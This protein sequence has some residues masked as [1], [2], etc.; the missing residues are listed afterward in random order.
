MPE[1]PRLEAGPASE[2]GLGSRWRMRLSQAASLNNDGSHLSTE[3]VNASGGA[4]TVPSFEHVVRMNTWRTVFDLEYLA[5]DD[6]ALRVKMPFELRDRSAS[7]RPIESASAAELADMQRALDLHHSDTVLTGVRDVELTAATWWRGAFLGN[8]RIELAYGV[9]LPFGETES[10]P[11]R[12]DSL[13]NLLPHEHVQFGTGTFDPLVQ[14]TWAAPFA[15]HWATGLY[16]SLRFP[17]YENGKDYR[18]SREITVAGSVGH[19]LS[20]RWHVRGL[21][22]TQWSGIAEWDGAPDVNTG[23]I[24][25]YAGTG[26]E[27][28]GERWTSSF[29]ILLPVSQNTLGAGSETF[30]LGPVLSLSLLFPF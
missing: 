14:L 5:A 9:S 10:N 21:L 11:Y 27:Y 15:E 1:G 16:G 12:R 30:D 6:L 23:W 20:E 13:G 8:D 4:V 18:A 3:G 17:L 22:T 25:W 26:M 24:A 19:A 28:R 29:Q 7:I 2:T